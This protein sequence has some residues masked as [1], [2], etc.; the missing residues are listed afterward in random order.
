MEDDH[1]F[2]PAKN[3]F[4]L[5]SIAAFFAAIV[6]MA[7]LVLLSFLPGAPMPIDLIATAQSATIET[8]EEP[9]RLPPFLVDEITVVGTGRI[10]GAPDTTSF[11]PTLTIARTEGSPPLT[12]QSL[13]VEPG[14]ALTFRKYPGLDRSFEILAQQKSQGPSTFELTVFA[15]GGFSLN[16]GRETRSY[17]PA[18]S[19]DGRASPPK[20]LRIALAD[21]ALVMRVRLAEAEKEW[22]IRRPLAV[23]A[24]RFWDADDEKDGTPSIFSTIVSGSIRFEKIQTIDGRDF[25]ITL[26]SGQPLRVGAISKGYLR[27]LQL[28]DAGV[29][30]EFSGDIS[31]LKT[32]W[33]NR[34]RDHMPSLLAVLSSRDDLKAA[35]ALLALL[36]AL[37]QAVGWGNAKS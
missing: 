3:R 36:F 28:S 20:A 21:G 37:L 34:E 2:Q 13:S 10:E 24:V 32:V 11:T 14:T 35:G 23:N 7:G 17:A 4:G 29:H 26:R 9:A 1:R 25:E 19:Q 5:V 30:T 27:Q 33:G 22:S 18:A 16:G 31:E 6:I 12:V 8:M 15:P